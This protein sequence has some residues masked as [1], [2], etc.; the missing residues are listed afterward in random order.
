MSFL[1]YRKINEWNALN[2]ITLRVKK[3]IARNPKL[4]SVSMSI[5]I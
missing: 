2:N 5:H 4:E 3:N 1:I